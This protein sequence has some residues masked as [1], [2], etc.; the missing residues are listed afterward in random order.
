MVIAASPYAV[1]GHFGVSADW[2]LLFRELRE[3]R[4]ET[5]EESSKR[6]RVV[7]KMRA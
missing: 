3:Q 4:R 1:T 7:G 5:H 6:T 2:V